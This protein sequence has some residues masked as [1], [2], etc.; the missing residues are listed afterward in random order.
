MEL[1]ERRRLSYYRELAPL[2]AEHDVKLVQHSESGQLFVRKTLVN[3][4]PEI[5]QQL[6]ADPIPNMPRIVEAVEDEGRLIVIE[7]YLA[8]RTLQDVADEQGILPVPAVCRI[9]R[10]L[11]GILSALHRRGI[12][13]RDI[14]PSNIIL[15]EDGIVKLLDL[16]AAKVYRS[17]EDRDTKL[18]GTQGYAA[19]EQYGF[20]ASS[21]ATD[22]YAVGIVLNVLASGGFP[23]AKTP[24]DEGLAAVIRRCTRMEP[25]ERFSSAEELS[26]ALHVLVQ[27][28]C[29]LEDDEQAAVQRTL[30]EHPEK[31]GSRC[32]RDYLPPGFRSGSIWKM[33]LAGLW[34]FAVFMLALSFLTDPPEGSSR[35]DSIGAAGMSLCIGL[36]LPLIV[37]NYRGAWHKLRIDRI[38]SPFLK[39]VA[40]CLCVALFTLAFVLIYASVGSLLIRL[41]VIPPE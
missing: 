20:G 32:F 36:L 40:A 13:H 19:P 18:I 10:Q 1:E 21:P 31:T 6:K 27:E 12:V 11:C 28:A 33:I 8:G 5:F 34:Y 26:M 25:E 7:T 17:D 3:Y 35:F 30:E 16:D 39:R 38:R 22:I 23:P 14:K 4:Q 41:G 29:S 15:S 24:A 37:F 9:G 2:D